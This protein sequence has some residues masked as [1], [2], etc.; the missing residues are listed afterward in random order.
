MSIGGQ[1]HIGESLALDPELP[2]GSFCFGPAPIP[3]NLAPLTSNNRNHI[4]QRHARTALRALEE[5]RRP[6]VRLD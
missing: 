2:W 5:G 1:Q 3:D 4:G 6:I